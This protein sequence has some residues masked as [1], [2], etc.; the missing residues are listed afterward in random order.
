MARL[1]VEASTRWAGG[2]S[3]FTSIP[4]MVVLAVT[5]DA[6]KPVTGV[7]AVNVFTRY[8]RSP[9]DGSLA[10]FEEAFRE[11]QTGHPSAQGFYSFVVR[12]SEGDPPIWVQDQ[13]FLLITIRHAGNNGQAVC[14]AT[15][16]QAL[17]P[18]FT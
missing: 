9:D 4:I 5:D 18:P 15:Y 12:P 17:G 13:V 1:H 2:G 14:L 11:Y 7:Q 8:V 16:H 3:N 10:T 6:G